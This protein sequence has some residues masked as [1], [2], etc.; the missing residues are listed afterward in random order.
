M[1]KTRWASWVSV[2]ERLLELKIDLNIY[3]KN[4]ETTWEYQLNIDKWVILKEVY[5]ILKP[6][7]ECINEIRTNINQGVFDLNMITIPY[8]AMAL[9]IRYKSCVLL[10]NF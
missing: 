2:A 1:K 7:K 4:N 3:F 10:E 5:E 8:L 6:I 9:D